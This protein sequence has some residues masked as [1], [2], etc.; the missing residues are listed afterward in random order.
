MTPKVIS[1]DCAH[2]L[3][4]V[5]WSVAR[6]VADVC[7]AAELEIPLEGPRLYERMYFDRLDDFVRVNMTRDHAL[8]D[9]WWVDLGADW[10]ESMGIAPEKSVELQ[11]VSEQIGF[12]SESILFKVYEDVVPTLQ[13]VS[14]LGI[15]MAVLSNWDYSLH[16]ALRGAGIYDRFNLV[17]AS[18]EH[19]VG[20]PDARLFA[21]VTEYF[22]VKAADVLHV[23]D[24]PVDDYEGAIGAGMRAAMIDRSRP[25][26]ESPILHD[27]RQIE[28]AF[29][30]ID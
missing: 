6:Y 16:K 5:D 7:A 13:R 3:L 4:H 21:K 14:E 9:Q 30:W 10:L 11:A 12:G 1:F 19:G 2:T 20:K 25:A 26:T 8:C 18:L 17:V 23:G 29:A 27:L 22:G 15:P 28:E 24:H